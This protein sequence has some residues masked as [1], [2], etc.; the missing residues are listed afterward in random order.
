VITLDIP[1]VGEDALRNLD[2]NGIVR[3][4][5]YVKPGDILVGK[6]TPKNEPNETP[7]FRLLHAI[8][9]EK[10]KEVKDTSLRVPN[11]EGGVVVDVK[12]FSADNKDD[13]PP[14]TLKMVKIHLAKKRK[15]KPGDKVAGRH[16]NK[17]VI[18]R[19]LPEE[20][21]P[22]LPDGTPVDIVLNPLGVPSRTTI[23]LCHHYILSNINKLTSKVTSI[24][25]FQSGISET[26]TTHHGLNKVLKHRETFFKV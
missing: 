20:D 11:G 19:V 6:V 24:S 26:L 22:F 12:V 5:A 2:E 17:G 10:A 1:N 8:F 21:M 14:G 3:V 13:L 23:M 4:G 16:G 7:E 18:S 25:G 9:G 15:I